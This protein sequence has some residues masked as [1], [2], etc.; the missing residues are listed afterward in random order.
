MTGRLSFALPALRP[1]ARRR[2]PVGR[3]AF[4]ALL[5]LAA[6][7]AGIVVVL[8]RQ[9]DQ[10]NTERASAQLAAATR[11]AASVIATMQADLSKRA[12]ALAVSPRLE[13]AIVTADRGELQASL[14][15]A[16]TRGTRAT[17][18]TGS[19]V[20][21]T[22]PRQP[23]LT[24]T[25]LVTSSNGGVIA[26]V[27]VAESLTSATLASI[28]R[29][30][31]HP[32]QAEAMLLSHGRVI[33]GGR[34]TLYANLGNG[35]IQIGG[36]TFLES[37]ACLPGTS[38]ALAVVEPLSSVS[39]HTG[40]FRKRALL[41]AELTLLVAAILVLP[42]TRPF[43]RLLDDLRKRA[44][45]DGLTG[46]ANRR[47]FE[48]RLEEELDRARRHGTHLG[49]VI[50]DIDNFKDIN[51]RYGHQCGDNVLQVI[52]GALS[53]SLRED[54]LAARFGGEE[55]AIVLPGTGVDGAV[56][57]AEHIRHAISQA[58][59]PAPGGEEVNLTA[60]FGIAEF[61]ACTTVRD[62]VRRA[63]DRLYAA[64][65]DGKN[66]VSRD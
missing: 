21:G 45:H 27:T 9:A 43:S 28:T 1:A 42:L 18:R 37:S 63:D 17:V 49:L 19:I 51:D 36:Q 65:R 26:R 52:A 39:A 58:R 5:F 10:I 13:H 61:P 7:L 54:D 31:S 47:T 55:F 59:V 14:R 32:P 35:R 8:N 15:Q 12:S 46:L 62:L 34:D 64:K 4:A 48:E 53:S 30:T 33:G 20:V 50:A 3:T 25:A 16:R 6:L 40:A 60:S 11:A 38:D 41:A 24:S 29:K 57:V 22:L 23:R 66:R 44:D 2:D 56:R